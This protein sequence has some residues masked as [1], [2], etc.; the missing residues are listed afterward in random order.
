MRLALVVEYDG[1]DFHGSQL[2]EGVRTVQGELEGALSRIYGRHLRVAFA[3]RTDA[4][5]HALGQVAALDVEDELDPCTLQRALNFHTPVDIAIRKL[6]MAREGFDPRRDALN[7]EYV[8]RLRDG[9]APHPLYRNMEFYVRGPL[10][11]GLMDETARQF[12]GSHD[13]ASF[14]GPATPKDAATS[15]DVFDARV[16]R[17]SDR[18][19]I[20]IVANAFLHQQIRRM[21]AVLV[22]VGRGR[23]DRD[24]VA[25]MV[26]NPTKGT[27]S[28]LL[29]PRGLCLMSIEYGP[30]GPFAGQP[31]YN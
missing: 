7:R 6:Q 20:R 31:A 13:F 9:E 18:L 1:A 17:E 15:R 4:G 29:E 22:E 28:K 26:G 11:E 16:T 21:A 27:A 2:Q 10:D 12:V 5:V 8:Y 25:E 30:E 23:M 24:E 3:S 14:A 19:E